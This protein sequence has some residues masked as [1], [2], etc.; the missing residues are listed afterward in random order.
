LEWKYLVSEGIASPGRLRKA[1]CAKEVVAVKGRL[2]LTQGN[3]MR[4]KKGNALL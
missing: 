3:A 1:M 2:F 4:D